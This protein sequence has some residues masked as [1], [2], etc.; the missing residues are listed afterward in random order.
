MDIYFYNTLTRK[1]ELFKP[2]D[3]REIRMYS[4]GMLLGT[5]MC[6]YA[7]RIYKK[8][9]HKLTYVFFGLSSLALA[10]THYYGVLLAGV[11]N[12]A[13]FIYL[14]KNRKERNFVR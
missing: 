9:I 8:D 12:L 7:Y 13:L 6:I 5:I 10:Y 4:L 11:I 2:I 1:K 3:E 14:I